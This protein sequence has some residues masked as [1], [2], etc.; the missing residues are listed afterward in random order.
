MKAFI[1][2]AA[3]LAGIA[4]V[5]LAMA[6]PAANASIS[7]TVTPTSCN[8]AFPTTPPSDCLAGVYLAPNA[9]RIADG[10]HMTGVKDQFVLD[11]QL[12]A[13][14]GGTAVNAPGVALCQFKSLGQPGFKAVLYAQWDQAGTNSGGIPAFDILEGHGSVAQCLKGFTDVPTTVIDTIPGGH[15]VFLAI[16]QNHGT[17]HILFTDADQTTQTG[18]A[19]SFLGFHAW[20]NRA[21]IGD[22]GTVNLL[23]TPANN[24]L[25][26]PFK[27]QVRDRVGWV[28]INRAG[29]TR[30]I[31]NRVIGTTDGTSSGGVLLTPANIGVSS[32]DVFQG[33]LGI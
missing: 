2:R 25:F 30:L 24:F 11:T 21:G 20:F 10:D 15:T 29:L 14:S 9:N 23:T 26:H 12:R 27:A 7:P 18:A 22:E 8:S 33:Q 28:N 19:T 4:A 5:P 31:L 1:R 3:L 6:L 32:F 17:H 16:T 13:R